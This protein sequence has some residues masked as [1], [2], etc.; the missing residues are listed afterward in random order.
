MAVLAQLTPNPIQQ[1]FDSNGAPLA[2]GKLYS[3]A[4]GTSTPQATYTDATAS[5]PNPNPITLDSE[6]RCELWIN[7]TGYKF[8]LF[9]S[10]ANLQWTV[11]QVF[12][13]PPGFVGSTQIANG[14]VGTVQLADSAVTAVKIQDGA[15][16]TTKI[17]NGA[18]IPIKIPNGS[19]TIS[20]L[21]PNLDISQLNKNIE[22]LFSN[23]QDN[24]GWHSLPQY[25]WT[26][27]A[28]CPDPSPFLPTGIGSGITWSPNEEYVAF[29]SSAS[30]S[31]HLYQRFGTQLYKMA[32]PLT[33]PTGTAITSVSWS[34]DS[35]YLSVGHNLSPFVTTYVRDGFS[36]VPVANPAPLPTAT[37][38]GVAWSRDGNYLA[39]AYGSATFLSVYERVTS[40]GLAFQNLG[41][42][43][44]PSIGALS[45]VCWTSD[46]QYLAVGGLTTPGVAVYKFL[47]PASNPTAVAVSG[48]SIG[49]NAVAYSPDKQIL[50][51]ALNATPFIAFYQ[52]NAGG[53]LTLLSSPATLPAAS[54]LS[55]SWS[56]NSKYVA[57]GTA[58]PSSN[59]LLIYSRSGTVF[60]PIAFPINTPPGDMFGVAW[61]PTGQFVA[62]ACKFSPYLALY[63]TSS[64][65]FQSDSAPWV[66]GFTGD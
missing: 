17:Q 13:I 39:A 23:S 48:S 58:D 45:S 15:V 5:V 32:F 18:V 46:A 56:P 20:K 28:R 10:L 55:V 25:Q 1:F 34:P 12:L 6:G 50:A 7:N 31:I 64:L 3:Y 66:R 62:C 41:V 8:S 54:G 51:A 47:G 33:A 4:A 37:V 24:V 61:S 40:A 36:F 53:S 2:G 44:A 14:A 38:T 11:D 60:T 63:Q 49:V 52:V 43:P 19:L 35:K 16:T 21:D 57:V 26:T 65:V 42:S 29:V 59:T 9:D 27:P 30:T 22:I